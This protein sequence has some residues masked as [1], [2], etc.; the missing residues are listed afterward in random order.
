[1]RLRV[2][3]PVLVSPTPTGTHPT[4]SPQFSAPLRLWRALVDSARSGRASA[5]TAGARAVAHQRGVCCSSPPWP[6]RSS[7]RVMRRAGRCRTVRAAVPARFRTAVLVSCVLLAYPLCSILGRPITGSAR[8][9]DR[10]GAD[11]R[12]LPGVSSC[13]WPLRR[14]AVSPSRRRT[15]SFGAPLL[16]A[17]RRGRVVACGSWSPPGAGLVARGVVCSPRVTVTANFHR[18]GRGAGAPWLC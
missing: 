9:G 2:F 7:C 3:A 16:D 13:P 11:L 14:Y 18:P 6:G 4:W 10:Y 8:P 5:G 15:R 1:V 12:E 17:P